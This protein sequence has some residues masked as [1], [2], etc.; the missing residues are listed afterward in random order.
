MLRAYD[1]VKNQIYSLVATTLL[2]NEMELLQTYPS[3]STREIL[4]ELKKKKNNNNKKTSSGS[5]RDGD[6]AEVTILFGVDATQIHL[7]TTIA[8]LGPYDYILFHHPHLGYT[9]KDCGIF[10][11]STR[12]SILLA[13]YLYSATQ[14]LVESVLV[15]DNEYDTAIAVNEEEQQEIQRPSESSRPMEARMIPC[16]HVCLCAGQ[17]KKWKVNSILKRLKLEYNESPR[18]VNKPIFPLLTATP[19]SALP[20]TC[21]N[22]NDSGCSSMS[23]KWSTPQTDH[24][25]GQYG[26]NHQP[27]HPLTTQL[28]VTVNSHHHFFRKR[29]RTEDRG[30]A[31]V[32]GVVVETFQ[33]S[34]QNGNTQNDSLDTTN[35]RCD[36]C[37]QHFQSTEAL[38][39]HSN[40]PARPIE[41][42]EAIM[43]DLE[44]NKQRL[45]RNRRSTEV[46]SDP[47]IVPPVYTS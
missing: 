13:H 34:Q 26:Y 45:N 1:G 7:N 29:I 21:Q 43:V 28:S 39:R 46:S 18:F 33:D 25:L 44:A 2:A 12:H 8:S 17:S 15:D 42:T 31:V 6:A 41:V 23:S 10:D 19:P 9:T 37:Q 36:I 47:P 16:V 14:L 4:D 5:V 32:G 38:E 20:W 30:R 35:F 3:R 24:W 40:S 11:H 27:T 22:E